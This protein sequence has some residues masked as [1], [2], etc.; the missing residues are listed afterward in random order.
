MGYPVNTPDDD[1]YYR[2]SPDGSYAY[3]SSYRIGG[4]GEKDIYTINYIKNATIRGKVY[5]LRDSTIIPG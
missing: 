1:T 3:L 5:S 2:L 4:Y